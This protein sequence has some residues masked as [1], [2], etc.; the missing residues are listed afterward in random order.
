MHLLLFF[1]SPQCRR[2][3][4]LQRITFK[5]CFAFIPGREV[6]C[7]KL[8]FL[9]VCG[10]KRDVPTAA[11]G[12]RDA[13]S[14]NHIWNAAAVFRHVLVLQRY[15]RSFVQR[16]TS[17][18]GPEVWWHSPIWSVSDSHNT[19]VSGSELWKRSRGRHVPATARGG[20][21]VL[22]SCVSHIHEALRVVLSKKT[23]AIKKVF[24]CGPVQVPEVRL[25]VTI[26]SNLVWKHFCST[27]LFRKSN[28]FYCSINLL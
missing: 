21:V 26:F 27:G 8:S 22:L 4:E 1:P 9:H 7:W 3:C 10:R 6:H 16:W 20:T 25:R 5:R 2:N 13:R 19:E 18:L 14:A 24:C 12:L 28:H 11:V 15:R 23:T 17:G